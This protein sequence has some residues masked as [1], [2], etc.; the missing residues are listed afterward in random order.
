MTEISSLD[1]SMA[2]AGGV[3]GLAAVVAY[4]S[5]AFVPLPDTLTLWL[6]FAFGPLLAVS[7]LGLF[8]ALKSERDGPAL[9]FGVALGILAGATVTLML[10]VQVGNNMFL[11]EQLSSADTELAREAA[12]QVHRAVNRVQM[13][14]D[15]A[16]DVFICGAGALIGIAMLKHRDFGRIW[17]GFG[18]LAS[19]ALLYLNLDTYPRG[20]A[21]AGSVDLGPVVALWFLAVFVKITRLY[22][23]QGQRAV[24]VTGS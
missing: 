22:A 9:R 20:P 4:F 21:Y 16:W 6:A 5:A 2:R 12:R 15:V 14:I 13:L 18:I 11:D 1:R 8:H 17:G 10:T 24:P 19:A 7:F 23:R 3:A